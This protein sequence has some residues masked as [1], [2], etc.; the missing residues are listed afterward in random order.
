MALRL[1]A[2]AVELAKWGLLSSLLL[3]FSAVSR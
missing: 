2:L 3:P 1:L